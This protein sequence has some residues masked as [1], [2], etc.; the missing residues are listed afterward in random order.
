[1]QSFPLVDL[2]LVERFI[3]AVSAPANRDIG[4]RR[5]RPNDLRRRAERLG[6]I[7]IRRV[8]LSCDDADSTSLPRAG[9]SPNHDLD[10]LVERH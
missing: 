1:M 3:L 5:A 10:V 2:Q 4:R 8:T 6:L 7:A 9:L